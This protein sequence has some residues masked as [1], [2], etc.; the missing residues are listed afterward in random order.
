MVPSIAIQFVEFQGRETLELTNGYPLQKDK[1][2]ISV[3]SPDPKVLDSIGMLLKA[4]SSVV[5]GKLHT[6]VHVDSWDEFKHFLT[7]KYMETTRL[8]EKH[9][10]L[11]S[12]LP[13]GEVV[14][15]GRSKRIR[16]KY[17]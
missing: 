7:I 8:W 5:A 15:A 4:G 14:E 16:T 3:E 13:K 17:E 12:L 9:L 2:A 6:Y 1:V 10:P 11:G